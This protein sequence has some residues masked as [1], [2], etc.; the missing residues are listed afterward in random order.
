M[1][2]Q[3]YDFK[4]S[5]LQNGDNGIHCTEVL[6]V[7]YDYKDIYIYKKQILS[8]LKW[9]HCPYKCMALW[10]DFCILVI[11]SCILSSPPPIIL[12]AR[13]S[14]YH[15]SLHLNISLANLAKSVIMIKITIV[16]TSTGEDKRSDLEGYQENLQSLKILYI[17]TWVVQMQKPS[18]CVFR[19][20]GFH[21]Y[22]NIQ[23]L[24]MLLD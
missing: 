9:H 11:S 3:L 5:L 16:V 19:I 14:F 23:L 22:F 8:N 7:D 6:R 13:N 2:V 21:R 1:L 17:L 12:W 4:W 20:S 10:D 15:M 24:N 18:S